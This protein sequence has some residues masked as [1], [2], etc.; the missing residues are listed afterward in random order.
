MSL[1]VDGEVV[2]TGNGAA[3]LGN[4]LKAV[5]WLANKLAEFG[6]SLRPGD[7]VLAGAL[8]ASVAV[9]EG[10]SV[11]ASFSGLGDVTAEFVK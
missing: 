10:A 1:S 3:V 4:P 8:H 5:A 11:R 7:L 9:A 6:V 2:S